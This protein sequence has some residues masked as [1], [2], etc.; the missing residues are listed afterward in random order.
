MI[1]MQKV[2]QLLAE[3]GAWGCDVNAAMDR[4]LDDKEIFTRF[5]YQFKEDEKFVELEQ[6]I[7]DNNKKEAFECA[8]ALKGVAGNLSLN[9]LYE[10]ISLLVEA[11]RNDENEKLEMLLKS[12]LEKKKELCT[13]TNR[14]G[15]I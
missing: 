2:N 13:I 14:A 6:A 5:L 10:S 11:L 3:L 12:V 4:L 9:P 7:Q 15:L 1:E 8:H